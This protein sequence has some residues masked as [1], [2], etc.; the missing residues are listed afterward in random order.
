MNESELTRKLCDKLTKAGAICI[1]IVGQGMQQSGLPD[2]Y[3]A[4]L[5]WQGWFEAKRDWKELTGL[6]KHNL[7]RLSS[8]GVNAVVVRFIDGN[9]QFHTSNDQPVTALSWS[10]DGQEIIEALITASEV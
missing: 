9:I 1:S 7:A 5:K 3:V 2:R 8:R 10:A 6:Q 4:H